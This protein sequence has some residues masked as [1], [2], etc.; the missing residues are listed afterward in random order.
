MKVKNNDINHDGHRK[1]LT[2]LVCKVGIENLSP[3][4]QVEY[5]LFLIIPRVDVNPLAH[6]LLN[7]YGN[8]GNIIDADLNDLMNVEGIGELAAKKI[9]SFAGLKDLYVTSKMTSKLNLKNRGEFLDYLEQ[10][11]RFRQTENLFLFAMS[12]TY[13]ITAHRMYDLKLIREVGLPILEICGFIASTNPA[14]IIIAHNHPGGTALPSDDDENSVEKINNLL[15]SFECKFYDSFIVGCDG[16]Y[17]EEQ[18]AFVRYF[19]DNGIILEF[20]K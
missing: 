9:K 10:L 12:S 14:Y 4:Q 3:I 7:R 8:F 18:K 5:F 19:D 17:G 11:L 13:K 15:S 16:I 1:R 6:R 2:D 20:L